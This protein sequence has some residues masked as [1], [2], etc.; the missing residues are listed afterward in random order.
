LSRIDTD[1][2]EVRVVVV[3]DGSTDGTSE[4]VS[5]EFPDVLLIAGNGSLHYAAGTNRGI[6]TALARGADYIVACN[7]DSIFHDQFLKRLITTSRNYPRS[8]VGALLLLWDQ[9]HSVF[10]VGFRWK[11][12]RG[13]W[14][15]RDNTSAFELPREPFEVEGLAGNCVL[16]P[17]DAVREC[18]MM[19][20]KHFPHGWGDIQYFVRMRKA[21]W[22]LFV[23]PRAYVWC[24]PNTN[25]P[26]LHTLP[27]AKLLQVLFSDRRHPLNLQRQFIARWESAPDRLSAVAA[28]G[29]YLASLFRNAATKI[30]GRKQHS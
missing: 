20:E 8:I 24:E 5:A 19:D 22:R 25:P 12:R 4:A 18:G 21:G 10:Q 29:A 26:P 9:P 3:D 30:I 15:Q 14:T 17:A 6:S 1:G 7:D 27:T 2:L 16:I 23:D 28:Y 13:G 11:T